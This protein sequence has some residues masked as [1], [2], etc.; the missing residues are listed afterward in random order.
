MF[1]E[2]A[3]RVTSGFVEPIALA[4]GRLGFTPNGLTLVG[5]SLHI[6]VAWLIATGHLAA[7]GVL[8]AV[9]AGIDGLDGALARLTGRESRFGA[10][11]D[12]TMDRIS[13]VLAFL[14]LLAYAEATQMRWEAMLTLAALSGSL[15]VSYTRA[16]S[17]GLQCGTKAG[18]LGRLER[19]VVLVV[20]L[21]AGWLTPALVVIAVGAWLTVMQRMAD[22]SRRCAEESP[23]GPAEPKRVADT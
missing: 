8:L 21:I 20:G 3:R 10:F 7:G 1:T 15:M 12:S 5:T 2:Q 13:E 6:V 16:R 19:M 18:L 11:F 9:A 22:V 23:P 14:G 17:E 4:V